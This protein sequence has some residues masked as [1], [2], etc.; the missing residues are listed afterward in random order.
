MRVWR[1]L[2][3]AITT[4]GLLEV[5]FNKHDFKPERAESSKAG[6][7]DTDI[8]KLVMPALEISIIQGVVTTF[9]LV[10]VQNVSKGSTV[11]AM[12]NVAAG[13][14]G[15]LI[16]AMVTKWED[17]IAV[18]SLMILTAIAV[19]CLIWR[20]WYGLIFVG[21]TIGLTQVGLNIILT[22]KRPNTGRSASM[23]SLVDFG[24]SALSSSSWGMVRKLVG[25]EPAYGHTP[26]ADRDLFLCFRAAFPLEEMGLNSK[27]VL[28]GEPF[29]TWGRR[30]GCIEN[31]PDHRNLEVKKFN[32]TKIVYITHGGSHEKQ[33]GIALIEY[34]YRE[35]E[36]LSTIGKNRLI[37]F[38]FYI[39]NTFPIFHRKSA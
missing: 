25:I 24:G 15:M 26:G 17:K 32:Y 31:N 23:H 28:K 8:L 21:L 38:L 2:G 39:T 7:W 35:K 9:L 10:D 3:L 4:V 1:W 16:P 33:L 34:P 36:Q 29:Q 12:I 6:V 19:P 37:A 14:A 22:A 18:R 11:R 27:L 13:V 5:I 30:S 20:T